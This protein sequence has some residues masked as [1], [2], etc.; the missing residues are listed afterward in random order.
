MVAGGAVVAGASV[1]AVVAV[2]SVAVGAVAAVVVAAVDPGDSV[3]VAVSSS[4]E[5]A[6][7][8]AVNRTIAKQIAVRAC[9]CVRGDM[10]IDTAVSWL[11]TS[12]N[13]SRTVRIVRTLGRCAPDTTEPRVDGVRRQRYCSAV[14]F[15]VLGPVG[16]SVD[17]EPVIL[18]GPQQRRLLA[19]M[20]AEPGRI[21]TFDS[22]TEVLWPTG[23]APTA[24]RRTLI[25]YVSRLRAALGDGWVIT[26]DAGYA[27]D[28]ER[29]S[30]DHRRFVGLVD[31]AL[32]D[33][34]SR[35]VEML[36]EALALWRG[37]VFGELGSEW[38]A[39]PL[40]SRLDERRLDAMVR[41]VE[42]LSVAGWD[43]RPLAEARSLVASQPS[44]S[45]AVALLMRGL[46]A[47]GRTDEALSIFQ[48]H[49]RMLADRSGLD[50]PDELIELDRSIAVGVPGLRAPSPA[51]SLRGYRIEELLGEGAYGRVYRATQPALLRDVAIKV[52]RPDIADDQRF[53]RRFEIEAQLVASVEHP[54]IVPLY[55][56]WREPGAAYLVFRILRGGSGRDLGGSPMPLE[57]ANVVVEQIGGALMAAHRCD[58]VHRDVKPSNILFDGDGTA[59]LADFGI[60]TADRVIGDGDDPRWTNGI[61]G[62]AAQSPYASPEQID[63]GRIDARSD[64]FG[65]ASTIWQFLTGATPSTWAAPDARLNGTARLPS[66]SSIRPDLPRAIDDVLAR[67]T[68]M[69]PDA[70]FDDVDHFVRAWRAATDTVAETLPTELPDDLPNPYK[71]LRPFRGADALDFHGRRE[72]LD[73]LVDLVDANPL[74]AVVG[75]SGSG[76]S[77]LVLAGLMRTFQERGGLALAVTPG[78]NPFAELAA[79]MHTIAPGPAAELVTEAALRADHGAIVAVEAIGLGTSDSPQLLIVVDQFEELWTSADASE[80][81][82]FTSTLAD[83]AMR[84]RCRVVVTIRADW[85]DRPLQDSNVG[86][87]V[88]QATFGV[89]PMSASQLREA[90]VA[91][92]ASLGVQFEPE[93]VGRLVSEAVDQPGTLPLLQFALTQM[94]ERRSGALIELSAYDTIG[95]LAG[96]IAA[97]ADSIHDSFR[98]HERDTVRELFAR[99]V[100]VGE[101]TADTRRRIRRAE[102]A[103]VPDAVIDAF[104]T[105]RL[106]TIDRDQRTREPTVEIAHESLLSSWPRLRHWLSL[107]REWLREVRGLASS[108]ALWNATGRQPADLYRGARLAV[109]DELVE[110][111]VRALTPDES[112]FLAASRAQVATERNEVLERIAAEKRQN[113]RLRRSLALVAVLLAVASVAGVVALV[114][115]DRADE[116]QRLALARLDEA[117]RQRVEAETQRVL[118]EERRT[119]ANEQRTEADAQ[120]SL[121]ES[122]AT[123]ANDARVASQL[124]TLASRSLGLR[125]SER[126]VA[127]LLAVEA[128]RRSPDATSR[129]A[130]FGTFT[131]DPG[132]LGYDRV[133]GARRVFGTDI[134]GTGDVLVASD[135]GDGAATTLA[136]LDV[137]TM[138]VERQYARL[139]PG[140][141]V[142]LTVGVSANGKYAVVREA[143][144]EDS[145]DRSTIV[146]GVSDV[147]TGARVGGDISGLPDFVAV[148]VNDDGTLVAEVSML[149]GEV[150]VHDVASGSLV[151]RIAPVAIDPATT[152]SF[153]AGAVGFARD[154]LLYVGSIT[155]QLRVF[156]P[157]TFRTIRTITVPPF[158]TSGT[159]RFSADGSTLVARGSYNNVGQQLP[160]QLGSMARID[161]QSGSVVWAFSGPNYAYGECVGFALSVDGDRLWCGDFYGGI[162]ERSMATG[163]RTGRVLENQRGWVRDMW[164]AET[165]LGEVLVTSSNEGPIVGRWSVAGGGPIQRVLAP[166]AEI[167][168]LLDGGTKLLTGRANGGGFPYDL[169]YQLW[170]VASGEE[171]T[172]LPD[173]L[174]AR[175]AETSV[176]G[177]FADGTIGSYDVQTGSQHSFSHPLDPA[178]TVVGTS[179]DATRLVLGYDD[180]TLTVL[181]GLTGA[182]LG[183]ARLPETNGNR[184]IL[185]VAISPDGATVYATGQRLLAAFDVARGDLVASVDLLVKQIA[186]SSR[187]EFVGSSPDGTLALYDPVDL[188]LI[189][190]LP[191]GRGL[192]SELRFSADGS[193]LYGGSDE[194][195]GFVYDM[196]TYERLGDGI[197]LGTA[198]R[199]TVDVGADGDVLA[200]PGPSG[201]GVSLWSLDAD[202][203]VVAACEI[204]GRNLTRAEWTT[205]LGDL[206]DYRATCPEFAVADDTAA[207]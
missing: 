201:L 168:G 152:R 205:Y 143:S 174:Y 198:H 134:P 121:A 181:D 183:A 197:E 10:V 66:A 58:V 3:V 24:A 130:L 5:Q 141:G 157:G 96:S 61:P 159:F 189:R 55:D 119:E 48:A 35:Q 78:T 173:L 192:M 142:A 163:Q 102:L 109:V 149:D 20:L 82:R 80:H 169:D 167:V 77:S 52:I 136:R 79:A 202:R 27:I 64:Q 63:G 105:E 18:G 115:R 122:E 150:V 67:A 103:H 177:A 50:P 154:G 129:S 41:R 176:T 70:R 126:D 179:P 120:R 138:T 19:A 135:I 114:Q 199:R 99:L 170:D 21:I 112:A 40:A 29:A 155:D 42:S 6:D 162:T 75:P 175:A 88:S 85:F 196:D 123:G 204:A 59:Y 34:P 47:V 22:L 151:A 84:D 9:V 46:H 33:T 180:G 2:G 185:S 172:S 132:F 100:T 49:R 133:E 95:G 140:P 86:P 38:W 158:S 91:P 12:D 146:I 171:V 26:T 195:T 190:S 60:A 200:L 53:V 94:F 147:E 116:Q 39:R 98:P 15:R 110:G 191:G 182:T 137:A 127:A 57:R 160:D 117:E 187:G 23:D 125:S 89:T 45:P 92:A 14:E 62:S 36:D 30:V 139:L 93:L 54:H 206:G 101:G 188:H 25:S 194:G 68:S 43:G 28:T 164:V 128:Y 37:P 76:K 65:L 8:N 87:L 193:L 113:R 32:V 73:Q 165:D 124:V 186:V 107:D 90:I 11:Q 69:S 145:S 131:F 1:V 44:H 72:H 106:L 13:A 118:A 161:L 7:P 56:F 81:H 144:D 17:G 148:A 111:R 83:L 31:A 184:H 166:G 104:V 108:T 207:G 156:D 4:E 51:R 153:S 178:P 71:G 74:T 203:W 16:A 97:Q